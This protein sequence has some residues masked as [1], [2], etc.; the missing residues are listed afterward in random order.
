MQNIAHL[1]F[2]YFYIVLKWRRV[3]TINFRFGGRSTTFC[4]SA[5]PWQTRASVVKYMANRI[6]MSVKT[7]RNKVKYT[8]LLRA[9][10]FGFVLSMT[11]LFP[12]D[13]A[14]SQAFRHFCQVPRESCRKETTEHEWI[15][16]RQ[17]ESSSIIFKHK[18]RCFLQRIKYTV[19]VQSS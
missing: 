14:H 13:I 3:A 7:E 2:R 1:F 10:L 6:R 11:T 9:C 19:C 5:Q 12:L 15:S 16:I 4:N 17:E 8:Y 18:S